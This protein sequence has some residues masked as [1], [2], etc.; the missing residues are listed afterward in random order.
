[1]NIIS[2]SFLNFLI[3]FISSIICF[4]QNNYCDFPVKIKEHHHGYSAIITEFLSVDSLRFGYHRDIMRN[5]EIKEYRTNCDSII[6]YFKYWKTGQI[7]EAGTLVLKLVV[8][9]RVILTHRNPPFDLYDTAFTH[10]VGRRIGGWY[11]F[12]SNGKVIK[13]EFY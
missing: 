3:F 10:Y 1:M 6:Y 11:Y 9:G 5:G 4:G 7:R 2:K 13:H 12:D 8:N